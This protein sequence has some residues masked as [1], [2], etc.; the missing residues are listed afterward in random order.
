[1]QFKFRINQVK[2]EEKLFQRA[3]LGRGKILSANKGTRTTDIH[4]EFKQLSVAVTYRP[5]QIV[6]EEEVSNNRALHRIKHHE[7]IL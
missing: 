7:L 5:R 3:I 4:R 1:M 6:A 2:G